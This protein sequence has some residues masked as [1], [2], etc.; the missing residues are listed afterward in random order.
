MSK[1]NYRVSG[2]YDPSPLYIEVLYKGE[3][4]RFNSGYSRP[5]FKNDPYEVINILLGKLDDETSR[6]LFD[7]FKYANILLE[8]P[9]EHTE[10]LS[11]I[12]SI[13]F[14]IFYK[15]RQYALDCLPKIDVEKNG[16]WSY[17]Y[18]EDLTYD[19]KAYIE[20]IGFI[21]ALRGISPIMATAIIAY[22]RLYGTY[23][24]SQVI[25]DLLED[26][27]KKLPPYAKVSRYT[28]YLSDVKVNPQLAIDTEITSITL[29]EY[30]LSMV[31]VRTA[32]LAP[33]D[34]EDNLIT[35][36]YRS[37]LAKLNTTS[38]WRDMSQSLDNA[39]KNPNDKIS[40]YEAIKGARKLSAGEI[41]E[42]KFL[43]NTNLPEYLGLDRSLI[44]EEEYEMY[45]N[46]C[47]T[48]GGDVNQPSILL[49]KWVFILNGLAPQMI[50]FL[51]KDIY[52][53]TYLASLYVKV[54]FSS[55]ISEIMLAVCHKKIDLQLHIS[56]RLTKSTKD[57]IDRVKTLSD[58]GVVTYI[59]QV[60]A[61]INGYDYYS[62]R[63][64]KILEI[65][66][67]VRYILADILID[68][69]R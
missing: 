42:L 38:K 35:R 13:A 52:R 56:R 63:D 11:S 2:L 45:Y 15:Y 58:E 8:T 5:S 9:L 61:L 1:I 3:C 59:G 4:I 24:Y 60:T 65:N 44:N 69:K 53:V 55:L 17:K 32:P 48:V 54:H 31:L 43:L 25:V 47:V 40:I 67:D 19:N 36:I 16:Q 50:E 51:D 26:D 28:A 64:N 62:Y 68:K 12:F 21:I 18:H 7:M 27:I 10:K 20:L 37:V 6:A 57:D 30:L 39:R 23:K 29:N 22:S 34:G 33:I 14:R 49:T 66:K 41:E 46:T